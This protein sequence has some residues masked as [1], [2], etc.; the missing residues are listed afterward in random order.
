MQKN[1]RPVLEM[2]N[3]ETLTRFS[4]KIPTCVTA[5]DNLTQRLATSISQTENSISIIIDSSNS[6][7][8]GGQIRSK[9][10]CNTD[11]VNRFISASAHL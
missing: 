3:W 8:W 9:K 10:W 4:N 5:N 1:R 11:S 7:L 2:R 6:R